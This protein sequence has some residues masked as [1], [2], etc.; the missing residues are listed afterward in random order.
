MCGGAVC[1]NCQGWSKLPFFLTGHFITNDLASSSRSLRG[2]GEELVAAVW[3]RERNGGEPQISTL[4][5]WIRAAPLVGI[6][7]QE[8]QMKASVRKS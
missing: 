7:M 2:K 6:R 1:G 4:A 8:Q 3:A 5:D